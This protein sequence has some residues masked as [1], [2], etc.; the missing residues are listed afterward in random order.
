[1]TSLIMALERDRFKG[2]FLLSQKS[3][4]GS[5]RMGD[6]LLPG[7]SHMTHRHTFHKLGQTCSY[8]GLSDKRDSYSKMTEERESSPTRIPTN[9]GDP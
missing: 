5:G 7:P 4:E 8:E 6:A 9:P 1:M 3:S 2:S